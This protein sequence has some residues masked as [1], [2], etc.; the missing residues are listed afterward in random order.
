MAQVIRSRVPHQSVCVWEP[1]PILATIRIK[2]VKKATTTYDVVSLI[3]EPGESHRGVILI[4]NKT[5]VQM[6][7][8]NL[9]LIEELK[10]F[11]AENSRSLTDDEVSLITQVIKE[12]KKVKGSCNMDYQGKLSMIANIVNIAIKLLQ[13][14][15]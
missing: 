7:K 8:S 5:K 1:N 12:L 13:I 10:E 2:E 6:N 11:L 4:L 9:K 3:W 15:N 14:H